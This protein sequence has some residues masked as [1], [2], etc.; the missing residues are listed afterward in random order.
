M[1]A[2]RSRRIAHSGSVVAAGEAKSR[3]EQDYI[4]KVDATGLAPGTPYFYRFDTL[5]VTS[6]TGQTKT[7]PAGQV[8]SFRL[9]GVVLKLPS[10]L[11]QRLP[12]HERNRLGCGSAFG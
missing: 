10:G 4:V 7:L 9:G 11:L 1:C 3:A 12:A 2:G 6:E 8:A 5:G